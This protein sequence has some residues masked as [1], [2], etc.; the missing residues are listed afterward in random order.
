[1]AEILKVKMTIGQLG[2]TLAL[3]NF[4]KKDPKLCGLLEVLKTPL[5]EVELDSEVT[6]LKVSGIPYDLWYE[7]CQKVGVRIPFPG[8]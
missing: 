1:M 6:Y 3:I 8:Y 7:F 4:W 2:T 5:E